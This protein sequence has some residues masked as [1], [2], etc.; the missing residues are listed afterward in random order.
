M[1]LCLEVTGS[2]IAVAAAVIVMTSH[3]AKMT[4]PLSQQKQKERESLK[5]IKRETES[6][7]WRGILWYIKYQE[8][9]DG[10]ESRGAERNEYGGIES[11]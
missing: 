1:Q 5:K 11:E 7:K 8:I 6:E 9:M 2:L 10:V 3:D 4:A